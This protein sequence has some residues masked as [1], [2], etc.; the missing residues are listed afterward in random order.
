MTTKQIIPE[1]KLNP[2][3]AFYMEKESVEIDKCRN[4]ISGESI[5]VYPPGIPIIAPGELITKE[6]ID[7]IKTLKEKDAHLTDMKDKTLET[8]L[9]INDKDK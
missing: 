9:V 3:E 8:I 6:I 5:M 4:R 7:Y 1:I 2:R